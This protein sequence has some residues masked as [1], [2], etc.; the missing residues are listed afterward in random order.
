ML[1]SVSDYLSIHVYTT[2]LKNARGKVRYDI[3]RYTCIDLYIN[4]L[5]NIQVS[6]NH[7]K[8][9]IHRSST[10]VIIVQCSATQSVILPSS[11]LI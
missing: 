6:G 8:W 3:Q 11:S 2:D 9:I 4:L 5:V 10:L 7:F 1:V